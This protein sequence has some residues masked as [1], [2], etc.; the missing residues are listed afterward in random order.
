MSTT[1]SFFDQSLFFKFVII[2]KINT[3]NRVKLDMELKK[4]R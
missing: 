3:G 4:D 2:K 1:G